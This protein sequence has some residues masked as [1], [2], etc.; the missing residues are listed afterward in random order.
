M[1]LATPALTRGR[2]VI[3]AQGDGPGLF[4]LSRF[5]PTTGREV[6]VA[7]NTSSRPLTQGVQV[8]TRSTAF[9]TLAGACAARAAAPGSLTITLPAFGYAVCAARN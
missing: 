8:E 3:R 2:Q 4:A 7:F 6:L 1:R 5:D 9:D